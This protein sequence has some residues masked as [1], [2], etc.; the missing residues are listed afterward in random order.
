MRQDTA[1]ITLCTLW[2]VLCLA[3]LLPPTAAHAAPVRQPAPGFQ[4][5]IVYVLDGD[6]WLHDLLS[7]ATRQLTDDGD[8]LLPAMI[9]DLGGPWWHQWLGLRAVR[10]QAK[11]EGLA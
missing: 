10:A 1:R 4:G 9:A 7:G 6:L 11:L 8:Y 3:A 5:E 2:I